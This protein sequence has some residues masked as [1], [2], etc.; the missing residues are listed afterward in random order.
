MLNAGKVL[1]AAV[2]VALIGGSLR[3]ADFEIGPQDSG[4]ETASSSAGSDFG[5]PAPEVPTDLEAGDVP[6]ARMLRKYDLRTD[7]KFHGGGGILGKAYL[8]LFPRFFLGGAVE[9]RN[10]IGS[11]DLHLTRDDAQLLARLQVIKEDDV[12]PAFSIGWDGP[13]YERGEAKGLYLV[14]SKELPTKVAFISFSGGLNTANVETF[15]GSRDL[16]AS[17]AVTTAYRN[18]GLFTEVDEVLHPLG[19]RWN[20]GFRVTLAPITLGLEFRD[21]AS[22]RPAT[23]VSRLLRISWAGHF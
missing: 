15:V 1:M 5:I 19:S 11:G 4:A 9:L 20:A 7:L 10:F 22:Q 8:G 13:A 2:F 18:I 23:P 16:R 3:A 12:F 21:L 17:F 6:T 14:L